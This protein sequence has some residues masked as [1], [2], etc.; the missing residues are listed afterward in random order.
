MGKNI[1][2]T[3]ISCYLLNLVKS[4]KKEFLNQVIQIINENS[5]LK[6]EKD[7]PILS[8]F[9]REIQ[10]LKKYINTIFLGCILETHVK[11]L[12]HLIK[13]LRLIQCHVIVLDEPKLSKDRFPASFWLVFIC[14]EEGKKTLDLTVKRSKSVLIENLKN[15]F[16]VLMSDEISDTAYIDMEIQRIFFEKMSNI[17]KSKGIK[18]G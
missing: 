11:E 2:I 4:M 7:L 6:E 13:T 12:Y 14:T 5:K 15:N 16:Y 17:I 3:K 9:V 18:G 8:K 10:D 1:N